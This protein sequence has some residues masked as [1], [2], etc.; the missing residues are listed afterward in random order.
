ML[1]QVKNRTL[2]KMGVLSGNKNYIL[3]SKFPVSL[4]CVFLFVCFLLIYTTHLLTIF[5][6]A[7]DYIRVVIN[8]EQ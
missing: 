8:T 7:V 1:V 6:F 3:I 4:T 5:P 2:I